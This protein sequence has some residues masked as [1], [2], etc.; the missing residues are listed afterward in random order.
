MKRIGLIIGDY[1]WEIPHNIK[2][3]R[4]LGNQWKYILENG[5]YIGNGEVKITFEDGTVITTNGVYSGMEGSIKFANGDSFTGTIRPE[6]IPYY[7]DNGPQKISKLIEGKRKI[8]DS[9]DL[10]H[11]RH[12]GEYV[13]EDK[14]AGLSLT[15]G[16]PSSCYKTKDGK[17]ITLDNDVYARNEPK[18]VREGK[19]E[20]EKNVAQKQQRRQELIK[21]YGKKVVDSWEKS[22]ICVGMPLSLVKSLGSVYKTDENK[23]YIW[24]KVKRLFGG[25]YVYFKVNKATEKVE[26]IIY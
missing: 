26:S 15:L 13:I 17:T 1:L 9:F 23:Y 11:G 6:F 20:H 3:Y 18:A 8:E 7:R 12:E 22:E 21:K 4:V 19:M 16:I 24:Y 5:D 10:M 25:G 2:D 14:I